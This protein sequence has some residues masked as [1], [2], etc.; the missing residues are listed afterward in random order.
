MPSTQRNYN[1]KP[2][3]MVCLF[4]LPMLGQAQ[5]KDSDVN[6]LHREIDNLSEMLTQLKAEQSRARR[7]GYEIETPHKDYTKHDSL[8]LVSLKRKQAESRAKIDE[9]TLDI[10]QISKQLEDPGKRYALARKIQNPRQRPLPSVDAQVAADTSAT[11]K[12]VSARSIDLA[13]V[14]LVRQGKSLDQARLLTIDELSNEQ[15]SAFYRELPREDRYEL[16]DIADEI[17][18]SEDV[19]LPDA[20]RSALYFYLF[21]K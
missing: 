16:Y 17:T 14:K 18:L 9:I 12:V 5:P 4:L 21:A 6:A 1:L 3:L 11:V 2:L 19:K 7:I 8:R 10:I 15:V 13:A 20:R